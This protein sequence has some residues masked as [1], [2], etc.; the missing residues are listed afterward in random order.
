MSLARWSSG[1]VVFLIAASS[2]AGITIHYEGKL[3]AASGVGEVLEIAKRVAR[4]NGWKFELV[5]EAKGTDRRGFFATY[6]GPIDGVILYADE[7]CEPIR[8]EFGK[9]DLFL[10]SYVKTQFAG[11]DTHV[12]IIK[13]LRMIQPLF[14]SLT[15]TDE[16]EYWESGDL[17]RLKQNLD[18]N[19]KMIR[20]A[21]AAAPNARG[22]IKL[23]AP[24]F[25]MP[26]PRMKGRIIDFASH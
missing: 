26:N 22:P 13:L 2:W 25:T 6:E 14:A 18:H 11:A 12:K 7:W 8:L 3:K 19:A 10:N 5:H 9:N 15:V 17:A 16:G 24:G 1:I 20:E 4:S 23:P 21:M